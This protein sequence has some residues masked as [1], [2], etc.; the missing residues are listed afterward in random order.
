MIRNLIIVCLSVILSCS[1]LWAYNGKPELPKDGREVKLQACAHTLINDVALT[2]NSQTISVDKANCWSA[3]VVAA[4][5]FRVMSTTTKVGVQHTMPAGSWYTEV[6]S[7]Y[8]YVNM[9]TTGA[10]GSFRSDKLQ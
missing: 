8:K 10:T 2:G 5:K 6:I 4:G 9:S 7:N 3:Y 1:L